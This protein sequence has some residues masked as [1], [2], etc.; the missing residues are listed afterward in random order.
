MDR[1]AQLIT[2]IQGDLA[3]TQRVTAG[4]VKTLLTE[5]G[6]R[7]ERVAAKAEELRHSAR[8]FRESLGCVQRAWVWL[9]DLDTWLW[10]L[11]QRL[12]SILE[13]NDV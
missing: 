5:R 3:D 4:I 8:E 7:I 11:E 6:P 1:R 2:E 12:H 13:P 10:R 9:D